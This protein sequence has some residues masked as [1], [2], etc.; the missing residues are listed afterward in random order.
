MEHAN[1]ECFEKF[2]F[3]TMLLDQYWAPHNANIDKEHFTFILQTNVLVSNIGQ[4]RAMFNKKNEEVQKLNNSSGVESVHNLDDYLNFA[5]AVISDARD[6]SAVGLK[7]SQA[8]WRSINYEN[9]SKERATELF[10]K[11]PEINQTEEKE[12]QDFMLHWLLDQ[13]SEFNM[14]VQIHTGYLA[15]NG[16]Q[17][18]NGQPIKLNNLF[19]QLPK[20]NSTFSTA[21][22]PGR[23]NLLP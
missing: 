2:N 4:A 17:L 9:I 1:N 21:D 23:V 7:N 16:N 6:N 18:D 22:S 8:Y 11:A 15:G 12:L 10:N 3:E 5:Q 13:A 14:P 20:Q 19:L